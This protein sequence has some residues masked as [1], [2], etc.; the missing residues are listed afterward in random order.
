MGLMGHSHM[1]EAWVLWDI[2]MIEAWAL[3]DKAHA[4]FIC[5]CHTGND[6]LICVT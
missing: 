6:S 4:S 1:N 3:W 5:T 2:H